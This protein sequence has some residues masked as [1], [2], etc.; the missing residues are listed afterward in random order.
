MKAGDNV[1]KV[2]PRRAWAPGHTAR[3][4]WVYE[5]RPTGAG[6]KEKRRKGRLWLRK[7]MMLG[8]ATGKKAEILAEELSRVYGLPI[9]D[10]RVR[11]LPA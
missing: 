8:G 3:E 1:I 6:R 4:V 5:L 9:L 7:V 10:S 2:V 11:S